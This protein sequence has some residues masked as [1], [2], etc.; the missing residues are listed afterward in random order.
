MCING[1][2]IPLGEEI[3]GAYPQEDGGFLR[4]HVAAVI[5]KTEHPD[6]A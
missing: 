5:C 2:F 4:Q 1:A 3:F 6:G